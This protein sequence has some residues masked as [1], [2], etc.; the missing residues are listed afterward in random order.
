M[1]ETGPYNVCK[2]IRFNNPPT[3]TEIPQVVDDGDKRSAYYRQ[4]HV[5][6]PEKSA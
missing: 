5:D 3:L 4:L 6:Q 1:K 2:Q